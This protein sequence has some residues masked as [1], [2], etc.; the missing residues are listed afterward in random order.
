M[1]DPIHPHL[2]CLVYITRAGLQKQQYI[3]FLCVNVH[4]LMDLTPQVKK[5]F[6][7]LGSLLYS[8]TSLLK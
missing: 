3:Y 1:G 7:M 2:D 8:E 5:M 4:K 6:K